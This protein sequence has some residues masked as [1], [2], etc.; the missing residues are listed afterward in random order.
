VEKNMK[1]DK[2][3]DNKVD[4]LLREKNKENPS[5]KNQEMEKFKYY[6]HEREKINK[7]IMKLNKENRINYMR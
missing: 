2:T 4:K 6:R 5:K 7:Q 1:E 3:I